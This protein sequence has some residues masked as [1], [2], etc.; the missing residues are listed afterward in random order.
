VILAEAL[1]GGQGYTDRSLVTQPT[2]RKYPPLFP[3]LL[4]PVEY[5][6]GRNFLAMKALV[7]ALALIALVVVALLLQ[8]R[9]GRLNAVLLALAVGFSPSFSTYSGAILSDAPYLCFSL[10]ALFLIERY[11]REPR[12]VTGTGLAAALATIAA[13]L[14][15]SLGLTLLVVFPLAVLLRKP[16]LRLR[17][18][19]VAAGVVVVLCALPAVGWM[20][21]SR[22]GTRILRVD[23]S[24]C[25][26][27]TS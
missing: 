17:P 27:P 13:Y 12:W 11:C 18:R 2:H 22:D 15:R 23:R 24:R 1:A 7:L 16:A 3:A 19:L 4:V 9:V 20:A 26:E 8:D 21:Y 14:T 10:L 6:F 5:L 25:A